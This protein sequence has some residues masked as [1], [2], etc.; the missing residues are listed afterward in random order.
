MHFDEEKKRAFD[1]GV[2]TVFAY[3][4]NASVENK[5]LQYLSSFPLVLCV[6]QV[7]EG[8][9][10]ERNADKQ[11]GMAGRIPLHLR[12]AIGALVRVTVNIWPEHGLF[13]GTRGTVVDWVYGRGKSPHKGDLPDVIVLDVPGY[14]GPALLGDMPEST[15]TWVPLASTERQCDCRRCKRTGYPLQIAKACTLH[16]LQGLEVG[17]GLAMERLVGEM[18]TKDEER[19]PGMRYVFH[20]RCKTSDCLAMAKPLTLHEFSKLGGGEGGVRRRTEM[21]RI[22]R[23]TSNTRAK[24]Q[25]LD[26]RIGTPAMYADLLRWLVRFCKHK[27]RDMA[28]VPSVQTVLSRCTMIEQGLDAL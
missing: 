9:H 26:R 10:A 11:A 1:D 23:M 16:G 20:T 18:G 24:Y 27:Y 3:P 12:L 7:A 2:R 8:P 4:D 14:D 25:A 6:K 28:H 19:N 5:N 15:A 13:N 22:R 21:T 17:S